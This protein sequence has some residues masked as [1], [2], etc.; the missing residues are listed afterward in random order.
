MG[1]SAIVITY[2]EEQNL[3]QCLKG[4]AFADEI[5]VLDSYSTDK[6]V[7][8]AE[9]YTKKVFQRE[10]KGFSAQRVAALSYASQEWVIFID[11]DEVVDGKLAGEI[12]SVINEAEYDTYQIPRLTEFLGKK[13]WHSGWYPDYQLRLAKRAKVHIPER[14]VHESLETDS[15]CGRLT[16]PIIHYSYRSLD[17]F[18]RKSVLYARAAA[19]QRLVEGKVFKF[20]DLLFRP[21]FAF[22]KKYII[23]QGFKDGFHGFLLSILTCWSVAL[24]YAM[25]WEMGLQ[26]KDGKERVDV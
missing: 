24:R 19:K 12:A 18:I 5:I 16:N 4:L 2:N 6:T 23:K 21:G 14:L 8:I 11:A 22:F 3:E 1:L 25:L 17:D 9:R 26:S 20:S 13:I 15:R 7:V 10:F